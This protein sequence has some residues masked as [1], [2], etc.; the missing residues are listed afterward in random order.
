LKRSNSLDADTF[1][2]NLS[3][4]PSITAAVINKNFEKET[5][6]SNQNDSLDDTNMCNFHSIEDIKTVNS[7]LKENETIIVN[8]EADEIVIQEEFN[9]QIN[10]ISNLEKNI[11]M[12]FPGEIIYHSE[13]INKLHVTK[14]DIETI[15]VSEKV[16]GEVEDSGAFFTDVVECFNLDATHD[17]NK[18]HSKPRFDFLNN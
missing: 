18:S 2:S 5:F 9:K 12:A 14:L 15:V 1:Y 16:S 13:T 4:T 3:Y 17:Y 6:E 10:N 11:E 7:I 8:Q